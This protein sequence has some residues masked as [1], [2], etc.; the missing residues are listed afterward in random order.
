MTKLERNVGLFRTPS[1]GIANI[2]GV[3]IFVVTR[4]KA[5][6]RKKIIKQFQN[7]A[8]ILS[9]TVQLLKLK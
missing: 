4:A 5:S 7:S 3:C 2:V 1:I 9:D 8:T 6:I